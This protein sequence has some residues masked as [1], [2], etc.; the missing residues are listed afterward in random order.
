MGRSR[1]SSSLDWRDAGILCMSDAGSGQGVPDPLALGKDSHLGVHEVLPGA[2]FGPGPQTS[3]G[4]LVCSSLEAR[5][6]RALRFFGSFFFLATPVAYGGAHP[7]GQIGAAA[8]SLRHSHS[9][10]RSESATY[11][12]ACSNA[13]CF[14]PPREARD[15]TL[16]LTDTS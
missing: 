4:L 7:R 1:E 16:I 11:T 10:A 14:N 8:A 2:G 9:N 3:G 12:A 5:A 6:L 15:Q 13:G